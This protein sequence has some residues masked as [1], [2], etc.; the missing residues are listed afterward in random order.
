MFLLGFFYIPDCVL[1]AVCEKW[2]WDRGVIFRSV[3]LNFVLDLENDW[4]KL[5]TKTAYHQIDVCDSLKI[6]IRKQNI[7]YNERIARLIVKIRRTLSGI[8]F[9]HLRCVYKDTNYPFDKLKSFHYFVLFIYFFFVMFMSWF[10]DFCMIYQV[11]DF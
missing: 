3:V 9:I 6:L 4:K 8:R 5:F 7:I 11:V 2:S 1:N 10:Y